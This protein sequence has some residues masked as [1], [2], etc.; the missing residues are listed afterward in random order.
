MNNKIKKIYCVDIISD[1]EN[2]NENDNKNNDINSNENIT[3]NTIRFI[4]INN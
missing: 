4:I 3:D 2:D 1:D